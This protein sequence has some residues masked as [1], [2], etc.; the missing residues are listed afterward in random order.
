MV[1]KLPPQA[2]ALCQLRMDLSDIPACLKLHEIS[3]VAAGECLW[4]IRAAEQADEL[5]GYGLHGVVAADSSGVLVVDTPPGG[6]FH[7]P[8]EASALEPLASGGELVVQLSGLDAMTFAS[9][10]AMAA[11]R[12]GAALETLEKLQELDRAL[13]EAQKLS[14]DRMAELER[15]DRALGEAQKIASVKQVQLDTQRGELSEA[16]K[17]AAGLRADLDSARETI[18]R[19]EQRISELESERQLHRLELKE[20]HSELARA[21]EELGRLRQRLGEIESSLAWR[22]VKRFT[23]VRK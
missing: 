5:I 22:A 3:A 11:S 1:F 21:R 8:V 10:L 7:V 18:R 14:L 16:Q 2:N 19:A 20:A 13:G 12:N 23:G 6:S 15:Y 9:Q 17:L 4:R